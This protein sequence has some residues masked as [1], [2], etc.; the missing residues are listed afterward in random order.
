MP[1]PPAV[2]LSSSWKQWANSPR[3]NAG[4]RNFLAGLEP[5]LLHFCVRRFLYA[6]GQG[7]YITD[8]SKGA[9][10]V[11]RAGVGRGERYRRWFSLLV[12][13]I[14]LVAAPGARI[15]A[16]GSSRGCIAEV[17]TAAAIYSGDALLS[18]GRQVAPH[19]FWARE[20]S[21]MYVRTYRQSSRVRGFKLK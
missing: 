20:K 5:M 14:D 6:P 4:F 18:A 10:L 7:Y 15:I 9:M 13:E 1:Y 8:L 11:K 12:E 17:S 16:V 3:V 2:M 21:N 19:S